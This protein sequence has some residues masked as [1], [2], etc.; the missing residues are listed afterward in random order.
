MHYTKESFSRLQRHLHEARARQPAGTQIG[1]TAG[2]NAPCVQVT[3]QDAS[4]E[5]AGKSTPAP[6]VVARVW[7]YVSPVA[8]ARWSYDHLPSLRAGSDEHHLHRV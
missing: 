3:I 7:S 8:W 5:W 4:S 6:S 2:G 1:S